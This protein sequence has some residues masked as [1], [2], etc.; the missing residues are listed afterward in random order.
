MAG[1]VPAFTEDYL[2][3]KVIDY[4]ETRG[5]NLALRAKTAEAAYVQALEY[6]LN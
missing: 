4:D 6:Y 3:S 1:V 5:M 2:M